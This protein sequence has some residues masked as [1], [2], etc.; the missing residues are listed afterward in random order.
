MTD[1]TTPAAID[2]T[3]GGKKPE[4]VGP[5]CENPEC[6]QVLMLHTP[7]REYCARCDLAARRDVHTT[8]PTAEQQERAQ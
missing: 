4:R 3:D 1:T 7:G 8:T 2:W 6:G 5:R